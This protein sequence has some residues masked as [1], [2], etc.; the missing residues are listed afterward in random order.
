MG[1]EAP[2]LHDAV[3]GN[4][5][6]GFEVE[7]G[8]VKRAFA[9]CDLIIEQTFETNRH[10]AVPLETRGLVAEYD[11]SRGMLTVWGPTKMTH[12]NWRIL[13]ELSGL[14]QS[15]IHFIEPAVGGGFGA[16]GEFYPED[17][18]IP[19]AAM[20]FRTPVCWIEDRS[21]HL[22]ST[23]HSRQQS[24]RVRLGLRND[25]AIAAMD[26][27]ILF[28][29]GGYTRT[30]GGV[31]IVSSSAMLQGPLRIP[32][33]RCRI[34]CVLTNKTPVGTYRSPGR[35]EANFVRERLLDMAAHRL[36][37]IPRSSGGAT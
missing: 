34:H 36:G 27:D 25:G 23:N 28:D 16:R 6:A 5:P 26:A 2:R 35:Y 13:S 1:P 10:A 24:Y 11:D 15:A 17:F 21:E 7:T 31:P 37:S 18:L 33:Y 14:P 9:G 30:H 12:T 20:H 8:D 4:E 3:P 32:N 19:F 22:K 29:M